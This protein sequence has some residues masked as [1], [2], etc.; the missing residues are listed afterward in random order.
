MKR[1]ILPSVF[2]LVALLLAATPAGACDAC[3]GAAADSPMIDGAKI[4]VFLLL[5]VT[6]SVQGGFVAFF[7]YLRRRA[8]RAMN[9][10]IEAEWGDLQRRSEA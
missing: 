5:G 2:A 10:E 7:V 8:R 6:V 1:H 4:G 9:E 3:Y